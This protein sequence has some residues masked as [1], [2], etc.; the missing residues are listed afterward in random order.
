MDIFVTNENGANYLFR[1]TGIG[2]FQEVAAEYGISDPL[3]HG[4]GVAVLDIDGD[5]RLDLTYGNWEGPHRL[6]A[7]LSEGPFR[8][9][10]TDDYRR[11]CRVRTVIAADFDNDGHEEILFNN[12]GEPNRLFGW[13]GRAWRRIE[14]GEALEPHGLGT[15]AAVADVDNDGQLEL[16]IAHGEQAAQPLTLYKPRPNANGWL[17]VMPLTQYGA[18][19]RG[20]LVVCSAE[21]RRQV[22]AID[23]GSGY[24][25]QME[26]VAHFGLGDARFVEQVEI[27]W[28]DGAT[29]T[30]RWPEIN[31]CL[32]VPHPSG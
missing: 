17:R 32:K 8:D 23:A 31:R 27:R 21:G 30:L 26:P 10:A 25:C 14:I 13:R 7:R 15:G 4:R 9:L 12:I 11:P 2:T 5:G 18:P 1:N 19:A 24:L 29:A 28:P 22:R 6:L 3:Q 20:A 16:L